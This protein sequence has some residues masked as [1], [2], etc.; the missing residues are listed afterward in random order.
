[1][2]AV[3]L[4]SEIELAFTDV[5]RPATSLRQFLLTDRYG[6]SREITNREWE[7]AAR[8]RVDSNWQDIPDSEIQECDCLLAH[9]QAEDFQYYLPAYMRYAVKHFDK[10]LWE[11]D[12]IGS[13]VFSLS[14]STKDPGG[15]AYQVAQFS[16]L[17][18]S[19]KCVIVQFLYFVSTNADYLQRPHATKALE[20]YWSHSV[21]T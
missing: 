5:V 19:Q 12:V 15:Y 21:G 7:Q 9:M 17:S 10:P 11:T 8:E 20:Q 6:M 1:M 13:V 4:I 16:S 18:S 14:P 3:E 2:E